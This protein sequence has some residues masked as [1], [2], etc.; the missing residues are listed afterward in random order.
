[1]DVS[2]NE[3]R[4]KRLCFS[5]GKAGHQFCAC[6]ERSAREAIRAIIAA[7]DPEDRLL[8]ADELGQMKEST[9]DDESAVPAELEEIVEAGFQQDQ[10]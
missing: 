9:F 10:S 1:M 4:R 6:P 7:F 3:M 5:C 8:L 2:M